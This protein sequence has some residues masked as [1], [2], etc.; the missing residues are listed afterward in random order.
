MPYRGK[1]V[2]E[3]PLEETLVWSCVNPE[4]KGWIRDNFTFSSEPI[5]P[6]CQ[7]DMTSGFRMLPQ[8]INSNKKS[9]NPGLVRA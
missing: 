3:L 4:C 5:C 7:S 9:G 8:L 2:E 6:L 1:P